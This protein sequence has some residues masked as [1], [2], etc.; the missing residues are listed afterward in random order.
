M[1]EV[2]FF[3]ASQGLNVRLAESRLQAAGE[4]G[5]CE[6]AS[7]VNVLHDETGRLV[8]RAGIT[9]IAP[10]AFHSLWCKKGLCFVCKD[11]SLYRVT[12]G[13]SLIGLR[14][15]VG[16]AR[17]AYL[18]LN[19]ECYYTNGLVNGVIRDDQSFAWPIGTYTGPL[20]SRQFSPAP[21]GRHLE[22]FSGRVF[23]AEGKVLWMSE[24]WSPGLFDLS[25]GFV[26]F[27]SDIK[28]IRAT[29]QGMFVSDSESTWFL[30]GQDVKE[31]EQVQVL[32]YPA[33]EYSLATQELQGLQV[34]LETPEACS[35]W[36]TKKG[37]VAGAADGSVFLLND[38]KIKFPSNAGS[39]ATLVRDKDIV[40]SIY[41]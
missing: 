19:R 22:Y 3:R 8:K 24:P 35:F 38:R 9:L 1:P 25:S 7:A 18:V 36:S 10:G 16:A 12:S 14:G 23:I 27:E 17:M 15:N 13:G 33:F 21:L 30:R 28:M 40:H 6:L 20:T 4:A 29:K 39:G 34:G 31:W 2:P 5:V 37:L 26:Q 11:E 32:N 41:T